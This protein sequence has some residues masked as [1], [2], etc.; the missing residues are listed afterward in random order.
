MSL[1]SCISNFL[2]YSYCFCFVVA[3]DWMSFLSFVWVLS[4]N[5]YDSLSVICFVVLWNDLGLLSFICRVVSL[6]NNS[7][8]SVIC[9]VIGRNITKNIFFV[10]DKRTPSLSINDFKV[11]VSRIIAAKFSFVA[12]LDTCWLS[13]DTFIIAWDISEFEWLYSKT[14]SLLA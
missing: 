7:F 10:I 8:L 9:F 4:L 13:L 14:L 2:N 1:E 5:D 12:S 6:N 3:S 11:Q